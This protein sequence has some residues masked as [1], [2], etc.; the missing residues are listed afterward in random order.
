M[1]FSKRYPFAFGKL[2]KKASSL[3]PGHAIFVVIICSLIFKVLSVKLK[4]P[5]ILL[6]PVLPLKFFEVSSKLMVGILPAAVSDGKAATRNQV[7]PSLPVS[8]RA[9]V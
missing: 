2:F 5:R 4:L 8:V 1:P 9:G 7:P 6:Q 3:Y